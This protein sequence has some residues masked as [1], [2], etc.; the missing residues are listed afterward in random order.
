[1]KFLL[2]FCLLSFILFRTKVCVCGRG[3][4][5]TAPP[6]ARALNSRKS[7]TNTL[8]VLRT[9]NA[10]INSCQ[11]K[12]MCMC[13]LIEISLR[14]KKFL[15]PGFTIVQ[16]LIPL[17]SKFRKYIGSHCE[18]APTIVFRLIFDLTSKSLLPE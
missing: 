4:G 16:F 10:T 7:D 8:R 11:A 17:V 18:T 12:Q 13:M 9:S 5:G 6:P 14:K 1:M 3:G 2:Q 15:Q